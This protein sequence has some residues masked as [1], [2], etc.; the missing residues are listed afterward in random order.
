[1]PG[2]RKIRAGG[3]GKTGG[4]K[5]DVGRMLQDYFQP[6]LHTISLSSLASGGDTEKILVDNSVDFS[7]AVLKWAKLTIRPIFD[8][9]DLEAGRVQLKTLIHVLYKRDQD[10]SSVLQCDQAQAIRELRNDKKL[11]RGPWWSST[12]TVVTSGFVPIM[13]GHMKPQVLQDIV[14]DR[15]EDLVWGVTNVSTAF[16]AAAQDLD[17]AMKG[18]VRVIT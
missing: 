1:M 14:M 15:E 12:P 4:P 8:A 18:Y 10:D 16:G 11:F 17:F 6:A 5:T 13:G 7:N 3:R 9:V 2:R